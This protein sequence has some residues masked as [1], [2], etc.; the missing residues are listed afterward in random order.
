MKLVSLTPSSFFCFLFSLALGLGFT[1]HV[2]FPGDFL[3]GSAR[4]GTGGEQ[5][6]SNLI[7]LI[8]WFSPSLLPDSSCVPPCQLQQLD[9][10]S[11]CFCD[12]RNTQ[13]VVIRVSWTWRTDPLQMSEVQW[14]GTLP[15]ASES[16]ALTIFQAATFLRGLISSWVWLKPWAPEMPTGACHTLSSEVWMSVPKEPCFKTLG[17]EKCNLWPLWLHF[18]RVIPAS[19]TY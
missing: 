12:S 13:V 3:L 2:S 16:S 9:P 1:N 5:G 8:W 7:L 15:W 10:A 14:Y 4:W 11:S 18:R 19:W 6:K 17:S